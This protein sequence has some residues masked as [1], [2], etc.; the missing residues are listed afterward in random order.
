MVRIGDPEI[1]APNSA[2]DLIRFDGRADA[3]GRLP[4]EP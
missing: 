4:F 3:S 1:H 2:V